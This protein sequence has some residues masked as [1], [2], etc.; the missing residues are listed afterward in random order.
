MSQTTT[1][2][3]RNIAVSLFSAW[4]ISLVL[5]FSKYAFNFCHW[6]AINAL[7]GR[8][9]FLSIDTPSLDHAADGARADL[10]LF[11]GLLGGEGFEEVG[12][13]SVH[14]FVLMTALRVAR[15]IKSS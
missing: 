1:R 7:S 10:Q 8:V 15:F 12:L 4:L 11:G 13:A 14:G 3:K 5:S 2:K 9:K 6:D